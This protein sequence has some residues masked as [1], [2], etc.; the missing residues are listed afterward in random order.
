MNEEIRVS[1]SEF[2]NIINTHLSGVG[3]MVVEG[4]LTQM[5]ITSKKGFFAT[6]KDKQGN[7]ILNLSGFTPAIQGINMIE[8]GKEVAVWGV[9]EVYSPY[10]K[11]SLKI[12]K[13]LP[14]GEGAL[15]EAYE[16][17]KIKL[18]QEGL[19]DPERKR[20]LPQ[21]ITRIALLTGKDS[22][23]YSDFTKILKE[24]QANLEVDYFPVQVQGKHA[25]SEI[26]GSLAYISKQIEGYYDAVVLTRGGG[27]L[28]DLIAFNEERIARKIFSM[29]IPIIVGVGHENDESIADFVADVRASTPSQAAYYLVNQN[30]I[31]IKELEAEVEQ[32]RQHLLKRIYALE[33]K[34]NKLL[35]LGDNKVRSRLVEARTKIDKL[36][37]HLLSIDKKIV[38][39]KQKLEYMQKIFHSYN[40]EHVV[41]RGFAVVRDIN[42]NVITSAKNLAKEDEIDVQL[43]KTRIRSKILTITKNK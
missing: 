23:A 4:E 1:V 22:A 7:A 30:R 2:N 42:G 9:P 3:E 39:T 8:E 19:F 17:L 6:L 26:L 10:G 16:K 31:F 35:V 5:T 24:N 34:F 18:K 40:P 33:S 43:Q 21:Y 38:Q 27:S 14:V 15:K 12:R 25:E 29:Q 20:P 41:S 32:I 11:F 37:F 13:I 28:E 36:K